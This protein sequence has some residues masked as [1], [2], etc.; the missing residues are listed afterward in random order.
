M[1]LTRMPSSTAWM[2]SRWGRRGNQ[3]GRILQGTR[4]LQ[5]AQLLSLGASPHAAGH[6][7][8]PIS[9]KVGGQEALPYIATSFTVHPFFLCWPVALVPIRA[10]TLCWVAVGLQAMHVVDVP[11]YDF[12]LHQRSSESRRVPPAGMKSTGGK[13]NP[14]LPHVIGHPCFAKARGAVAFCGRELSQVACHWLVA[15]RSNAE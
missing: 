4:R 3:G 10:H 6:R 5:D 7:S 13:S 14:N 12:K 11:I 9:W 2:S 8:C 15:S 1:P